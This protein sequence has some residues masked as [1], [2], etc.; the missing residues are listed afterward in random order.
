M[1]DTKAAAT[2][3]KTIDKRQRNLGVALSNDLLDIIAE[4]D[5]IS[6]LDKA[7]CNA[8][9]DGIDPIYAKGIFDAAMIMLWEPEY[10]DGIDDDDNYA[11][12]KEDED[13]DD[14]DFLDDL[15]D[16]DD[17]EDLDDLDEDK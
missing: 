2:I 6:E 16:D 10:D 3:V 14:L 13:D 5:D 17:D 15:D 7:F 11:I 8:I 1:I 4:T 9:D 12:D